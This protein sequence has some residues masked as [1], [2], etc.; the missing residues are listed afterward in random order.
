MVWEGR[1]SQAA[2]GPKKAEEDG[3]GEGVCWRVAGSNNCTVMT[4]REKRVP[5]SGEISPVTGIE[6]HLVIQDPPLR[7]S[8]VWFPRSLDRVKTNRRE[9]D[10]NI[11]DA[12]LPYATTTRPPVLRVQLQAHFLRV[13]F[14]TWPVSPCLLAS[15]GYSTTGTFPR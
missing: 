4:W 12:Q 7:S 8:K 2:G 6:A 14:S 15:S 3:K 10:D 1:V 5:L 9:S 11:D 13:V